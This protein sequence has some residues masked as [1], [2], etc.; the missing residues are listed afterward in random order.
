MAKADYVV[1]FDQRPYRRHQGHRRTGMVRAVR[2]EL[3]KVLS[4]SAPIAAVILTVT[5]TITLLDF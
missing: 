1:T 5:L 2:S 3:K 4:L